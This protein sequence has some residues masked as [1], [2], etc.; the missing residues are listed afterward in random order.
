MEFSNHFEVSL[1]PDQAW[2][3]LMDVESIVPCMPGAELLEKH[4]DGSFKGKISVRLGPV[5]LVFVCDAKFT[6]VDNTRHTARILASGSD[7]KGRGAANAQIGFALQPSAQGSKVIIDT[8][9]ELSGAVAQYG[10]GVGLIQNVANQIV[11]QFAQNLEARI[12]QLKEHQAQ[13]GQDMFAPRDT[14]SAKEPVAS[15]DKDDARSGK[16]GAT[17]PASTFPATE[18]PQIYMEGFKAGFSAGHAAGYQA[19]LQAYAHNGYMPGATS[20]G[21]GPPPFPKTKPISGFSLFFSSLKQTIA[22]W[23]SR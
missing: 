22:G 18:S 21:N 1:A 9:L 23:F 2:P 19:A 13:T 12:A 6:D 20:A 4:D 16:A 11:S 15:T 14:D 10:R 17:Q 7:A 8:Q 3:W 5:G